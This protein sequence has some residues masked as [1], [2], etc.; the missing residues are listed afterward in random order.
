M[1]PDPVQGDDGCFR[2]FLMP[3]VGGG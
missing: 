1:P 2:N 3:R